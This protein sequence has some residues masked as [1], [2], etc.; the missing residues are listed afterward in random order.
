MYTKM[1]I[2]LYDDN[3]TE[4]K[5]GDSIIIKTKRMIDTSVAK[6]ID[7]HTNMLTLEFDDPIIGYKPMNIRILDIQTCTLYNKCK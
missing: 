4:C 5:I 7:I 6:I 3:N 1:V 2:R